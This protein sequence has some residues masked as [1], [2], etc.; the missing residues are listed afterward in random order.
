MIMVRFQ[1]RQGIFPS[2]K[3]PR[4]VV[5]PNPSLI[6]RVIG[7]LSS[8]LNRAGRKADFSPPSRVETQNEWIRT[9]IL[10]LSK[11]DQIL[12]RVKFI[13]TFPFHCCSCSRWC[14]SINFEPNSFS[15]SQWPRG[16]RRGSAA[17]CLPGLGVQ[18]SSK[19]RMPLTYEFCVLSGRG[20]I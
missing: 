3:A 18:I 13:F 5:G 4:L 20:I 2:S 10:L 1:R 11:R 9:S 19:A 7:T 12:H 6:Q 8:G 17:S 15:R 16:L 14:Y